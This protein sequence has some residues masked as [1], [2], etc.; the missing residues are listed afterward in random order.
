MRIDQVMIKSLLGEE[1]V[2]FYAA[3]VRIVEIAYFV[4]IVLAASLFPRIVSSN[5]RSEA[6]LRD[7]TL[8]FFELMSLLAWF[9]AIVLFVLHDVIVVLLFGPAFADAAPVVAVSAW[10]S[11]FVFSGVAASQWAIAKNLT[12]QA[13]VRTLLGAGLNIALNLILIPRYGITGAAVATLIS[14]G[15]ASVGLNL[16][17]PSMRECFFLQVRAILLPGAHIASTLSLRFREA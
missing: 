15:I 12:R 7:S 8:L 6:S 10:A 3:A 1:D 16:V 11:V 4:P 13:M 17:M 2:G 14:Q 9:A 5:Q